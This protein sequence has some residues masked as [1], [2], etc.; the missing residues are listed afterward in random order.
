VLDSV[1]LPSCSFQDNGRSP[2]THNARKKPGSKSQP[3]GVG[4]QD[5]PRWSEKSE[6]TIV[7]FCLEEGISNYDQ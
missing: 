5:G 3:V 6:Y 4:S 1:R 2:P 7:F